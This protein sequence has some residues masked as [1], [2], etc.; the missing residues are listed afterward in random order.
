M[1]SFKGYVYCI[2]CNITNENYVGSTVNLKNRIYSHECKSN[3]C[4]SA[5]IIARGDYEIIL[6]EKVFDTSLVGRERYYMDITPNNINK[7]RCNV[8]KE[9]SKELKR[10]NHI[11]NNEIINIKLRAH[12][13]YQKSWGDSIVRLDR[14]CPNNFLLI[15]PNLF[16][17]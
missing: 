7:N 9:E 10:K 8:T 2:H 4:Y 3:K 1:K 14:D 12:R 17:Y 11:V 16:L 15:N 6:L 5:S 13:K